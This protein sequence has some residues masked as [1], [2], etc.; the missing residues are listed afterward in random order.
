MVDAIEWDVPVTIC[1]GPMM[2]ATSP[3]T[4]AGTLAQINA[5]ALFG[6][7]F[8]QVIKP[9]AKVVYG[10][11]VAVM[12]MSTAQCTYGSA[13][14]TLGVPLSPRWDAITT[15]PPS[16]WAAAWKPSCPMPKPPPRR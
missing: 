8:A 5:E 2:G 6:I 10:P 15:C 9:G 14:Q 4:L 1:L 13:E 7:V 11:H 3:A 16:G 12:D